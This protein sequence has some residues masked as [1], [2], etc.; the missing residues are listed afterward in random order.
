MGGVV[1]L[2]LENHH[3]APTRVGAL[4]LRKEERVKIPKIIFLQNMLI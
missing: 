4:L 3:L 1:I 2:N